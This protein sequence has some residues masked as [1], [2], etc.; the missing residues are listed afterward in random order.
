MSIETI[1]SK[2]NYYNEVAKKTNVVGQTFSSS[3]DS[4]VIENTTKI[5]G[6]KKVPVA[7]FK[8]S[9]LQKENQDG[10]SEKKLR[11]AITGANNKLVQKRTRCEFSYSE[12]VNRISIK[13]FDRETDEVLKEIPAEETLEM[14]EKIWDLAGLLV[15]EKR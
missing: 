11:D 7:V 13:V 15:D 12:E 3:L 9:D 1:Q 6:S 5:D 10:S 2:D 14:L 8:D 4:N